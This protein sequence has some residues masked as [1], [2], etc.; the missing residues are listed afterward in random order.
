MPD[1]QS[2]SLSLTRSMEKTRALGKAGVRR[3]APQAGRA[4][5]HE[6]SPGPFRHVRGGPFSFPGL[7]GAP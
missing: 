4:V 2:H 7:R 1:G 5:A 6:A 3:A